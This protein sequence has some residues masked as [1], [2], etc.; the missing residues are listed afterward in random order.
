MKSQNERKIVLLACCG[1]KLK[2][3]APAATLY[4][5]DLFR[6][7]LAYAQALSPDAIYILSAKYGLVTLGQEL[8]P[9]N[10]TLNEQSTKTIRLWSDQVLKQ[11]SEESDLE[12]DHFVILAG[13]RYFRNL[14]PVLKKVELPLEGLGIGKRLQWLK[15]HIHYSCG[16]LHGLFAALPR[17]QFPFNLADLPRNGIYIL[18]EV[19]EK[20]H[21]T[22]RIVRIGT[23]R[24]QDQLPGRLKEHF[25]NENKDRSIFR[26]NIGRALLSRENDPGIAL[27]EIDMTTQEARLNTRKSMDNKFITTTETKVT[28]YIQNNCSFV[29]FPVTDKSERL[30]LESGI[31]ATVA[32]CSVCS[33]SPDWL[34]R[35]SPKENIRSSGL[36]LIQGLSAQ[37]LMDI[38]YQRIIEL[39]GNKFSA[40]P[41]KQ[42]TLNS[43]RIKSVQ[44]KNVS[45]DQTGYWP[46]QEFL[47]ACNKQ[48][49]DLTFNQIGKILGRD[50]PDSAHKHRA[51][52]A[53]QRSNENRAN[54]R[55]WMEAGY[56]VDNVTLGSMGRVQFKKV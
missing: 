49:V 56:K 8:E 32:G 14:L 45:T 23:H 11:L 37:P 25:V 7:S 28:E 29:A 41:K 34:G 26:K 50:L 54:A 48:I 33:P 21:G 12:K 19:G 1:P 9:Y 46:L 17:F 15:Q 40:T 27:W 2:H 10:F 3:K 43:T 5:S 51:W 22:D 44:S 18:Y 31:I 52:W 6:K 16:H 20:A 47:T 24:G 35:Y 13:D 53:N 38:E 30:R 39:T 36:W 4:C 42:P 55:A